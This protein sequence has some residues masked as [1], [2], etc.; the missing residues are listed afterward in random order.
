M[1]IT[2][3]ASIPTKSEPD[4]GVL[5]EAG[6]SVDEADAA[7]HEGGGQ[8][9]ADGDVEPPQHRQGH[10]GDDAVGEGV[11]QEA[12]AAQHHPGAHDGRRDHS[13]HPGQQRSLHEL[14]VEGV[15]EPAH[16][17]SLPVRPSAAAIRSALVRTISR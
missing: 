12:E 15:E 7:D 1:M 9:G 5:A 14:G 10:A 4:P 11:A 3:R 13:E 6:S 8:Q 17:E 2:P 16:G